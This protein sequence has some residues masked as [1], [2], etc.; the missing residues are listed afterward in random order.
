MLQF[1][2]AWGLWVGVMPSSVQALASLQPVGVECSQP[3]TKF[4]QGKHS[5]YATNRE[6]GSR[7][8]DSTA[9]KGIR[10]PRLHCCKYV[11]K[12]LVLEQAV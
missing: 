12:A 1:Q 3:L 4:R 9:G 10:C 11:R 8:G 2:L 6:L 7:E 5:L